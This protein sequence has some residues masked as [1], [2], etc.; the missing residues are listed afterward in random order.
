[1]PSVWKSLKS[2]NLFLKLKVTTDGHLTLVSGDTNGNSSLDTAEIWTYTCSTALS[3]THTNN[4]VATG[5]YNG[6]STTDIASATV[7]VGLPIVPPLIHVEKIP[8]SLILPAGGGTVIYAKLVT[9]PG[10]VPLNNVQISDD[11]C[12]P[13][14]YISGDTN[15]DSKLDPTETWVYT[16]QT[17]LAKTTTNTVTVSGDANGI[18]ARDFAIATVVLSAAPALPNTGLPPEGNDNIALILSVVAVLISLVSIIM[19][20]RRHKV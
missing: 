17:N 15:G 6:V 12:S 9:N 16:C 7:V 13:V 14:Q 19:V 2:S 11:E 20:M 4:V 5:W 8:S 1:V 10:T 3:A 18:T